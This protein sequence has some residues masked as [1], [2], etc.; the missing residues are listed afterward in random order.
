MSKF[1]ILLIAAFPLFLASKETKKLDFTNNQVLYYQTLFSNYPF[2]IVSKT[3]TIM[4]LLDR[5][6]LFIGGTSR[7]N[8]YVADEIHLNLMHLFL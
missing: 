4:T 1:L 2:M 3:D 7:F 6:P 5:P 8:D